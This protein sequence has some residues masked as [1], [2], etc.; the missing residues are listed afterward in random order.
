MDENKG[1]I[2]VIMGVHNG[3]DRFAEAIESIVAQTYEK[4]EFI[5]CDD[6]SDDDSFKKLKEYEKDPRFKII[7]NERQ[8]G[9]AATLNHCLKYCSGEF[10]ARMDD[11]DISYPN[12]FAKQ[13]EYLGKHPEVSFLSSNAD[14]YDGT[15]V[16][17]QRLLIERPS[18]KDM[19]WNT[20]FIHPATMFR[21]KSLREVN[22]YRVAKETTR[23]QDYDLFMRMYGAGFIG[24]NLQEV[25]FR[26]TE[27]T[28]NF[29][30]RTFK[31][32]IGECRIRHYGYKAMGVY[33]WAAP[34]LLKPLLAHILTKAKL[35]MKGLRK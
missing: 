28:E 31:A 25:V 7:R 18:K 12:R 24:A 11:D 9:L 6:C 3:A 32:R 14:V 1:L 35:C 22:G 2:S 8:K 23:G 27:N 33:P 30:R 29:K 13:V 19:L 34:F 17:G 10:I 26:Y 5:I 21:A 4:W 16:V 20:R 15:V